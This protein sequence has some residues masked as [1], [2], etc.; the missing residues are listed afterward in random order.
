MEETAKNAPGPGE[1]L[2]SSVQMARF[3]ARGALRLDAVVPPGMNAEALGGLA[4][5]VPDVPYGT[6][7]SKAYDP[8]SFAA[9]LLELPQVAGAL[10][11]LVGP[12]P[13][14]DHHA[15]H[16]R[17]PRGG[18]AQPL[19]ADAI[20]DVRPDAFDVQLM[21]YPQDVTLEMGGTLSVPGSHLRRIN[22]TDTGRYQNLRGQDRLVCPAGTVVFLH[23]G[24]WHGGRRNDSD[25]V[26][27][28]FKVRFN[29]RVR[30]RLLWDTT[31]LDDPRVRHEL[32]AHFPWYEQAAGRLERY[33]RVLLWR[34]LTGDDTFDLDHWVT[35]VANRPQEPAA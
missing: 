26:R 22:E 11:S 5:G 3:V 31:D 27:Y 13:A 34:A 35:R 6:P 8:G 14:I 16:I 33:N 10:H 12:E 9:R 30:Q 25:V 20:I 29:P 4:D 32:D 2:L 28:M 1:H 17:E 15:V 18:E 23:H 24:I 21:Y 19:H 7:L